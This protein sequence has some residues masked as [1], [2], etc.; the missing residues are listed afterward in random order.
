MKRIE[1]QPAIL[2]GVVF[3]CFL[4]LENCIKKS[5]KSEKVFQQTKILFIQPY[6]DLPPQYSKRVY[7]QLLKLYP[8]IILNKAIKLPK[9]AF[10]GPRNR[11]RADT[12]ISVLKN[13]SPLNSITIGIT[14]KDISTKKGEIKD[15]GV[16]GLGYRPGN[17]CV[18]S[19]FRLNKNELESQLYKVC[20]H[21]IGHTQNLAHCTNGQCYMRNAEGKNHLDE[22]T[23]FCDKCAKKMRKSGWNVI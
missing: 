23:S 9:N 12:L 13:E 15:W 22:L 5:N 10:Y 8:N 19:T 14:T 3:L 17:A 4:F 7:N 11:Y 18:V 1:I 20:L 2:F 16:M 6:N 21:E